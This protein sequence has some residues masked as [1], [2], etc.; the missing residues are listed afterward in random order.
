MEWIN[1]NIIPRGTSNPIKAIETA[2]G[3]EPDVIFLL[4]ENITGGGQW[5]IDQRDL[6]ALLETLNPLDPRSGQRRTTINCIQF[7]DPDPL[8]TL[9][10]IADVHG[11]PRG[12][13]FL[14]RKELGLSTSR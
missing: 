9:K 2:M 10:K 1:Q 13:K 4:S 5:E 8:E 12:Y 7:L 3:F 6:L 11:G 14:D